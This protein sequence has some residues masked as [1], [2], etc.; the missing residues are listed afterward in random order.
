MGKHD[1]IVLHKID[2]RLLI[3]IMILFCK[4]F[5]SNLHTLIYNINFTNKKNIH[6]EDM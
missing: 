4:Y 3:N 1:V 5:I 2:V 6:S